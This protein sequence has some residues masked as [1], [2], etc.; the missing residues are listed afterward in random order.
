MNYLS[1]PD[2][3]ILIIFT[4]VGT[5]ILG[6]ILFFSSLIRASSGPTKDKSRPCVQERDKFIPYECG[7]IPIGKP[8][9]QFHILYYIFAL[10]F[11]VFDAAFIFLF[12]WVTVFKELG[13][14]AFIEGIIFFFIL[15]LG[16]IYALRK[17]ILKW[18]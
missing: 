1:V 7:N 10:I 4:L 2:Y 13:I 16:L 11:V 14:T 8:W 3:L 5:G 9:I 15:S 12:P 18:I 17:G 6:V